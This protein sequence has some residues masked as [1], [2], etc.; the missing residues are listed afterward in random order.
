MPYTNERL[1]S[2]FMLVDGESESDT[3]SGEDE[4]GREGREGGNDHIMEGSSRENDNIRREGEE[5]K[6]DERDDIQNF[7]WRDVLRYDPESETFKSLHIQFWGYYWRM[8]KRDVACDSGIT[9][10]KDNLLLKFGLVEQLF[11]QWNSF[12]DCIFRN[13]DGVWEYIEEDKEHIV[14]QILGVSV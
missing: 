7:D 11:S 14:R 5:K 8:D 3:S 6:K 10:G 4:E 9:R 13:G 2:R 1:R 12:H